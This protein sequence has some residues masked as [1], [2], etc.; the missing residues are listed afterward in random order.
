MLYNIIITIFLLI[1][2][3][4]WLVSL[5]TATPHQQPALDYTELQK[6][7]VHHPRVVYYPPTELEQP[8]SPKQPPQYLEL[9]KRESEI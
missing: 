1:S 5:W 2:G 9:Q 4:R 6:V 7:E 8:P 3:N